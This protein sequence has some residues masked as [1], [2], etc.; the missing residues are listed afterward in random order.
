MIFSDS[1]GAVAPMLDIA[2]REQPDEIFHLGDYLRDAETLS[3]AFPKIPIVTVPGNC[4]G[5]TKQ[6]GQLLLEREGV[7]LL[8]A[9]GHQWR[10][11]SGPACALAA[12]RQVGADVLL[13]GHTHQAVCGREGELWMM[14]P[15]TVGGW[16][17]GASYGVLE[18]MDG[19]PQCSVLP[20]S[21]H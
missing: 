7:R 12:A 16:R 6:P 10:V 4:D 13:Y 18:I 3:F 15:G 20:V 5:W 2:E 9:H 19:V 1:H 21:S 8:L 14:N 17:A 11:K